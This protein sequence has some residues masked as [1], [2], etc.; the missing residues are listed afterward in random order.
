MFSFSLQRTIKF[1]FLQRYESL[2]QNHNT[3][4]LMTSEDTVEDPLMSV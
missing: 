2:R 4:Y 1:V 3:D